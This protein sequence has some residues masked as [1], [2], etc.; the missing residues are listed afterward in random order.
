MVMARVTAVT[1]AIWRLPL[2][3]PPE[4]RE[5]HPFSREFFANEAPVRL[6]PRVRSRSTWRKERFLLLLVR[7]IPGRR[8]SEAGCLDPCDVL[9]GRRPTDSTGRGDLP[10]AGPFIQ[11]KANG[12]TNLVHLYRSP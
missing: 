10:H 2:V 6:G 7:E 5:R 11:T 9:A 3:L 12:F 1:V 8:P 4:Q